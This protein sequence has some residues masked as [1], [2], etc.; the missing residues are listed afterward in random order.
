MGLQTFFTFLV[1]GITLAA[2]YAISATGLVVT[3]ITSGV[4]NFAHG[5]V[6][7]FL[8]F[9]Y[10][11]LRVNR[12]WPTPLALIVTL[13]V[14]APLIGVTLDALVMRRLLRGTTVA[15]KLVVTL[16]L[17]LSFQ[18]L[19][20]ALWD[21]N[22]RTVPG[23]WGDRTF[24]VAGVNISWDQATTVF[25]ALAVAFGLRVLFRRTRLGVAMRA[26]V[27][28]PELCAIKGSSPNRITAASWALGSMLAGLAA[29]LI[30]P[31]LNLEVNGLSLL[32]VQA[33]AAA[34]VGRL[35][36]LPA[37]FVGALVLGVS[38]SM[39][40]GYLPQDNEIVRNLKQA[41][42]FI[43]LFG[44]LLFFAQ[45]R[46]PERVPT[47]AEPSPPSWQTTV[48]I[49]GLAVVGAWA[50]SGQLSRPDLTTGSNALVYTCITLSLV[51]LTGLSGQVSLMQMSFVGVGAVVIGEL[52]TSVP[53]IIGF[54]L[55]AGIT[56]I[57][58]CVVALPVL[59]LRGIYLALLTLAVAIL[60]DSLFFGNSN[61]F[62]GGESLA[63]P[64]PVGLNL[65][66]DR[67][68]FI[69]C[70]LA[71]AV[72]A[73]VF[74]AVRRSALGRMLNALR[75]S[76]TACQTMGLSL[77]RIKLVA[78]GMSAALAGAAGAL[79]GALQV[80]V[81]QLDFFYFKSLAVLL[82]ATIFGITSVSGAMLG[83]LFFVVLPRVLERF[84]SSGG[85]GFSG[86][87]A[88]QPLIIGLLAMY[89]ARHAGGVSGQLRA[90][91]R[92]RVERVGH[93]VRR[94]PE[95]AVEQV[96]APAN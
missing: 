49:G 38:Q 45:R 66:G 90:A 24:R 26:V 79:L 69:V 46:L 59:R 58:G 30:A 63:V 31:G 76:P 4:F 91:V 60:M 83:A 16:A 36:N 68:M 96:G 7:M 92:K 54:A 20:L 39:F 52:G 29:I 81:G 78:F 89:A 2:I 37:T 17:L 73:N 41:V 1:L 77:A 93:L 86:A 21:L 70:A 13:G 6:G 80:R 10:W 18:G 71:C 48:A 85:G 94:A 28:N 35:Q 95:P 51:L 23:L 50:L 43:V 72:F 88:L 12:G 34:V 22:L 75:D 67:Q 57:A 53:W 47:H 40:V 64:R 3:Y 56:G 8:A 19:A 15:T 42:P 87:Q 55:A 61:V 84:G 14:V 82:V 32:V 33:Y 62:G 11:E 44:A 5:A 25:A 9:V 27:D 65:N 74:L